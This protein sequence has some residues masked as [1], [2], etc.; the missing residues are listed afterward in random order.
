MGG[1]KV[2]E[3]VQH[4]VYANDRQVRKKHVRNRALHGAQQL[5]EALVGILELTK[6]PHR[7]NVLGEIAFLARNAL[8]DATPPDP[9]YVPGDKWVRH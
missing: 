3:L 6:H 4:C 7:K 9:D 1:V 2:R 8:I 5:R